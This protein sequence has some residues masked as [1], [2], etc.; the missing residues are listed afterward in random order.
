MKSASFRR[1][2]AQVRKQY[3]DFVS[4]PASPLPLGVLRIGVLIIA[5]PLMVIATGAFVYLKRR[6]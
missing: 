3:A 6:D 4:A 5:L 1:P 2:F